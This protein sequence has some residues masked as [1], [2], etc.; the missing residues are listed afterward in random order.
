MHTGNPK[1]LLLGS[2]MTGNLNLVVFWLL[3][4][5]YLRII[6][7]YEHRLSSQQFFSHV[8][9][10]SCLPGLQK[11]KCFTQRQ[12]TMAPMCL[13]PEIHPY[14]SNTRQLSHLA[15]LRLNDIIF[16]YQCVKLKHEAN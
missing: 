2:T 14:E 3:F 16:V 9:T 13:E 15:S 6:F 11:I 7:K 1:I 4:R 12:N 5:I 10:I 8:G